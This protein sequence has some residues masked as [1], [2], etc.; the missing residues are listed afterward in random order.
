M[1]NW[2]NDA[3]LCYC[4]LT[5]RSTLFFFYNIFVPIATTRWLQDKRTEYKYEISDNIY[6]FNGTYLDTVFKKITHE[7][8]SSSES[9]AFQ[10][11]I[12]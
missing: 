2:V 11:Y 6:T 3:L 1:N 10:Q 5:I 9:I 4:S 8:K 7:T 12:K